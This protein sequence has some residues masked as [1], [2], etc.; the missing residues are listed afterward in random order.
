MCQLFIQELVFDIIKL[1]FSTMKIVLFLS[2]YFVYLFVKEHNVNY[3]CHNSTINKSQVFFFLLNVMFCFKYFKKFCKH[4]V[5]LHI[6]W[7]YHSGLWT[8]RHSDDDIYELLAVLNKVLK[9][10]I[11]FK[12]RLEHIYS[13]AWTIYAFSKILSYL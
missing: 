13:T 9:Y 12:T 11:T 1:R 5:L 8:S 10:Y 7:F 4:C 2:Q 3:H 6:K